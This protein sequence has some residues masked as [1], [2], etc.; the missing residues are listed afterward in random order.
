ME[1]PETIINQYNFEIN[2]RDIVLLKQ[3]L[4]NHY[5]M[6]TLRQYKESKT[7]LSKEDILTN[8]PIK[9]VEWYSAKSKDK[10]D[11]KL[12]IDDTDSVVKFT[13]FLKSYSKTEDCTLKFKNL[14]VQFSQIV[15]NIPLSWNV[16]YESLFDELNIKYEK[17]VDP[18]YQGS[19]GTCYVNLKSI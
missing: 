7:F 9:I 8:M 13:T 17:I 19:S 4:I 11:K 16:K 14:M 5:N 2:N 18:R 6:L 12:W 15:P 1:L 10:K 3:Y